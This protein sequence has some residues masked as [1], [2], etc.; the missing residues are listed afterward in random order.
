MFSV[1]K[2]IET[3][4]QPQGGYIPKSLF[5]EEKY[6]DRLEVAEVEAAFAGIQGMATD[7][8]TRFM[9]TSNKLTAFKISILGAAKVDVVNELIST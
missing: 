9:L 1:T 5:V 6:D 4:S 7:Y 3:V 8:L 2:R